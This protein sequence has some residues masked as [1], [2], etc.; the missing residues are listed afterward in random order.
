MMFR[1][2]V[3]E[4]RRKGGGD[5]TTRIYMGCEGPARALHTRL[6]ALGYVAFIG[7]ASW[8]PER[9]LEEMAR[10]EHMIEIAFGEILQPR[11]NDDGKRNIH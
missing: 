7:W 2:T 8:V 11:G 5:I 9:P 6:T 10:A 3:V 4:P 1:I